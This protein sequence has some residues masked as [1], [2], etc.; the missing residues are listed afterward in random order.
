MDLNKIKNYVMVGFGIVIILLCF[1]NYC[2]K[3]IIK[4]GKETVISDKV[5]SIYVSEH[6]RDTVYKEI[7]KTKIIYKDK[8]VLSDST[9]KNYTNVEEDSLITI[10]VH[11]SLKGELGLVQVD[12][13]L[14]LPTI[15]DSTNIKT[16][17]T[18]TIIKLRVDTLEQKQPLFYGGASGQ[19]NPLTLKPDFGPAILLNLKKLKVG[20]NYNILGRTHGVSVYLPIR[21]SF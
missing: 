5:D 20:Y 1:L 18:E 2:T 9:I 4:Q 19:Y 7:T 21:L 14:K 3:P 17:I 8:K 11:T 10:T 16:T 12:Y 6:I 13:S 15:I